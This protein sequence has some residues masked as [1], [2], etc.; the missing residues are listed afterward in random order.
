MGDELQHRDVLLAVASEVGQVI[1]DAVGEAE[2]AALGEQPE[3]RRRDD[4]RVGVEL[5]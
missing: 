1:G 4:L 5:E 3:R 2:G